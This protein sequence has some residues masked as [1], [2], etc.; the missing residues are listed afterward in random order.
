MSIPEWLQAFESLHPEETRES[1]NDHSMKNCDHILSGKVGI[2]G[3]STGRKHRLHLQQ[4]G[5]SQENGH[6][7][8][9][10][11]VPFARRIFFDKFSRTDISECGARDGE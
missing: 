8:S 5:G 1:D 9:D 11:S 10:P 2:K 4:I 3:K 6:S 7:L